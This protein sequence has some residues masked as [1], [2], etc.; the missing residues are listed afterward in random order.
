M[1]NRAVITTKENFENNGVGVYLHWNGGRDSVTAF[2]TYCKLKGY[3][4][5]ATDDYGWARLCQVIGNAIGGTNT[6]GINTVSNLDCDNGDNG[7]Y[8][9]DNWEIVDRIFFEGAEQNN[10]DLED[11]LIEIDFSMPESERLGET[12]IRNILKSNEVSYTDK[13]K[14]VKVGSKVGVYDA[15]YGNWE[16]TEILGFGEIGAVVNGYDVSGVP[17]YDFTKNHKF[18]YEGETDSEKLERLK[19]NPNSYLFD[20]KNWVVVE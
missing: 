13:I 1:G 14:S 8:I 15:L 3:R 19:R 6:V 5:P 16:E 17:F 9:I 18:A 10:Y 12:L 20:Y 2:L 11:M 7:V 4:D